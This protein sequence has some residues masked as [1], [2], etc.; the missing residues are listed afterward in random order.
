MDGKLIG[1]AAPHV[2]PFGGWQTYRAAFSAL[3]MH[4]RERVFVIL[5]TSHYGEPDRFGLTRKPFD[6]PLWAHAKPELRLI[7]ELAGEPAATM[8]DYCHAVEHSIEFQV[9]FLQHL[10][11]PDIRILP[12]FCGS[13]MREHLCRRPA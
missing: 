12:I 5:G 9:L 13:Y 3:G 4:I 2:S 8:E 1:I 7:N 10:Y 6:T 11:G